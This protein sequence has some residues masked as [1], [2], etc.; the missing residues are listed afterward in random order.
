MFL[1]M[2]KCHSRNSTYHIDT[3]HF[4]RL[5]SIICHYVLADRPTAYGIQ[6]RYLPPPHSSGLLPD[7][8]SAV[9]AQPTDYVSSQLLTTTCS[10]DQSTRASQTSFQPSALKT[11]EKR[12]SFDLNMKDAAVN[13]FL[14]IN[15]MRTLQR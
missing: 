5:H 7:Q 13:A 14:Q 11:A 12:H 9:S 4:F 6:P 10:T 2:Y 1:T 15:L 3:F 8:E